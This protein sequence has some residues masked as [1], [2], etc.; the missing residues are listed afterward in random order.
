MKIKVIT[1]YKP[2]TWNSYTKR[3]VDSVLKNWPQDIEVTVYHESQEQDITAQARVEWIDIHKVQPELVKFKTKHKNDPVANGELQEIPGGVKRPTAATR[4][5]NKGSFLFDAVRFANKVFCVTHAIKTSSAFDYLIWLDADTYTF[6]PMPKQFLIDLLPVDSMLTYLGRENPKLKDGGKYPECGFVG[7]N[8]KHPEI[9]NYNND[10]EKMYITD[11]IFK[12]LEW[13]DCSTLWHLSKEYQKNKNIKVN[14]IGY[15]KGVRGHHVFINSELGLYMDHFKGKRKEGNASW[16]KD[17]KG[18]TLEATK[19]V[20][21][22]DYWK[23][24]PNE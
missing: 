2:G 15:W 14:D 22:L 17:F 12:L 10:W 13:T 19:D 21:N 3:A 16:K 18:Q 23:N 6:R 7:Y 9:Q 20:R 8:L 24:V 1:S 11:E 5:A 4:N